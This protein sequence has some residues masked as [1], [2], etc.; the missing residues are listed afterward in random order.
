MKLLYQKHNKKYKDKLE[1]IDLFKKVQNNAHFDKSKK[2]IFSIHLPN[3]KLNCVNTLQVNPEVRLKN[4]YKNDY[5]K[6][7]KIISPNYQND[8]KKLVRQNNLKKLVRQND[9]KKVVRQNDLKKI[10]RQNDLKK[11]V[12]QNDLK[13]VVRQNDLKKVVKQNEMF[14][15]KNTLSDTNLSIKKNKLKILTLDLIIKSS[16]SL[17]KIYLNTHN[18]LYIQMIFN[19]T[20]YYKIYKLI[21][22]CIDFINNNKKYSPLFSYAIVIPLLNDDIKFFNYICKHTKNDIINYNKI[23]NLLLTYKKLY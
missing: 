15:Y 20:M 19:A 10:V 23:S 3:Q 2:Y 14:I 8:L 5:K 1:N 16:P 7:E 6:T 11:V 17:I 22:V 13:K 9:L 4:N 18:Q 21:K 12:R